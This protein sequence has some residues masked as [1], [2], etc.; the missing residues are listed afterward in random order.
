MTFINHFFLAFGVSYLGSIPPGVLNLTIIDISLRRKIFRAYYFALAAALVEFGQAYV[1]LK[2]SD[3]LQVNPQIE[4]YIQ[5]LVVPIFFGLAIFYFLPKGP[6]KHKKAK[7]DTSSAFL[8]GLLL[9]LANPLAVIYWLVWGT[10]FSQQGWL[11]LTD[12]Y[13]LMFILGISL[14]SFATL[15]TYAYLSKLILSKMKSFN[16]W[17]NEII[18]FILLSLAVYQTY[19]VIT[20][21][22]LACLW[23]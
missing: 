5:V 18:G 2:F 10:Y 19:I 14:G 6:P 1:A 13:I 16:R 21:N 4:C 23:N 9:S 11:I 7:E 3:F 22:F 8:K 17:I 15:L 12:E 20:K